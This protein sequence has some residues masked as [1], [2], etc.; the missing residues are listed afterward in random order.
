MSEAQRE[1][2]G[3]I[4]VGWVGLVT[5]VS[6]AEI[7]HHVWCVDIDR[8]KLAALSRGEL[9]IHEPGLPEALRRNLPRLH[10]TRD[11][12]ELFHHARVAF[13]CVDTPPT[14]SGDAD[15]DRVES[16]IAA[17]PEHA[18]G[19]LL[20]MK[21]TVPVGTGARLRFAL[22]ARGVAGIRYAS[23]PEFLREGQALQDFAHP[24]R[25]IIG[26]T[27]PARSPSWSAIYAPIADE[28]VATDIAS[29]E[30]IKLAS[31]AFLATKI[32]FINEIANVC[33]EVGAQ[34]DEVAR[35]MGLDAR[36]GTSFLRPGVG[37]GG[38]CFPKDVTAL[39]QLA[40]NTG[41]HFQLLSRGDRRQRAAEAA[42][43][44]QA[45]APPRVA[46]RPPHRAL[47]PGLQAGHERH[48]RGLEHRAGR[49]PGGR[50]RRRRGL[51]PGGRRGAG[52]PLHA[53]LRDLRAT[54]RS[55]RPTAPTRWSS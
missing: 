27:D 8:D 39:K 38:R 44:Q 55:R 46:A 3:V 22:E 7:G 1:P 17:L 26:A 50:G 14:P 16:V 20:V 19:A 13:V 51:R 12:G 29:S 18:E 9:S 36:I 5:A 35:G 21:S 23:N 10:F 34:V 53:G 28:I 43:R 25:V 24:D 31:N 45:A 48:A 49:P 11:L 47:G 4:G 2:L 40:G 33:E 54:P 41:Y 6:F 37:F 32:S 52:G 15:L 42:R 30:M